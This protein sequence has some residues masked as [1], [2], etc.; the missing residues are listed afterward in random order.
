MS[1]VARESIASPAAV[2]ALRTSCAFASSMIV[3]YVDDGLANLAFRWI[4]KEAEAYD[5]QIDKRF[6]GHFCGFAQDKQYR[7]DSV[8]YRLLDQ[9]RFRFGRG[10]RLLVGQPS[11]AN[12]SLDVSVIHRL[13]ADPTEQDDRVPGQLRF[14]EMSRPYRPQNVLAFLATISDLDDYLRG[15]GLQADMVTLPADVVQEI[16]ALRS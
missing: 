1:I 14:P 11:T 7:S 5:L 4:L 2:N 9:L 8:W 3:A 13:Q 16:H 6:A 10:Q 15:L 12:L